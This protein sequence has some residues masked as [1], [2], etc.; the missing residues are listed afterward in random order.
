MHMLRGKGGV[1]LIELAVVL[2]IVGI[3]ALFLAPAIGEWLDNYRIR[4]AARDIVSTLNVA[5]LKAISSR[6]EYRVAFDANTETYQLQRGNRSQNSTTWDG[7]ESK[8]VPHNVDIVKEASGFGTSRN[9]I[10][11]N[12]N[13]TSTVGSVFI[14]NTKEKRY[15][16]IVLGS[17][18]RV[19]MKEGWELN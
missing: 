1:T 17:T 11:F 7:E 18:G 19:R 16:I 4:Q 8:Q 6:R 13:G 3:M 12:P 5:K 9:N 14:R 10:E 15:R 2:A